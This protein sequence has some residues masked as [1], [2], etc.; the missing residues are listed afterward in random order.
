MGDVPVVGATASVRETRWAVLARPG[1]GQ[2]IRGARRARLVPAE[3]IAALFLRG[4]S[5]GVDGF[6]PVEG[7]CLVVECLAVE[8]SS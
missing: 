5:S 3:A 6:Q 7:S 1:S 4:Y 2:L 8:P